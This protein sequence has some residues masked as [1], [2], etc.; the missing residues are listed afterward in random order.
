MAISETIRDV[1]AADSTL[2]SLLT[3]GVYSYAQTG[4]NGISR[5]TTPN[6][7]QAGGFLRPCAVVKSG[8]VKTVPAIRDSE[9]STAEIAEVFVY[10]DGDN[11]YSTISSARDRVIALLDRQ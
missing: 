2:T 3:G 1:L 11:G 4:R 6:A 9:R 5:I 8:D 7:Y 10:D